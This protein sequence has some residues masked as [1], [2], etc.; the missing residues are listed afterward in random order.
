MNE[1]Y[2]L[3]DYVEVGR[4]KPVI[5]LPGMEGAKEF[6]R[7]QL[8][9]FGQRYR[10]IAC[11]HVIRRPT[12]SA[13]VADYAA[14]VLRLMDSLGIEKAVIVGESF[15]GMVTQ[16]I[17]TAHPERTEAIVL[18]NTMDRVRRGGF[19]LNMFTM[20]TLVHQF[21]FLVPAS[22]R[23][24]LLNWV[25]KHRGFVLDPSPGNDRLV[26]YIL[27][28]GLYPGLGGYLDRII[29]GAKESYSEKLTRLKIPALVLR[30]SEDRLVGPE[31]IVELVGRTPGAE[32]V[33]ID[34]GGHCCQHSVPEATNRAILDWLERVGY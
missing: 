21:A 18:C 3:P 4:G 26:D 34:G 28:Y 2:P 27:E 14:D 1:K 8:D 11:G 20:T 15:G 6:W 7:Y 17:A 25:G 23:K 22:R 24:S 13:R 32:L 19:G 10:T 29:A 9:E 30:G 33:I 16:E 5:M 31:T 12:L